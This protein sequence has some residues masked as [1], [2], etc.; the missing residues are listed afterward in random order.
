MTIII[1]SL[2]HCLLLMLLLM[3]GVARHVAASILQWH[4][5]HHHITLA[6]FSLLLSCLVPMT[7]IHSAAFV[8]A[9]PAKE[10]AVRH[11]F[12][13]RALHL[14][15]IARSLAL[16]ETPK[17]VSKGN[18]IDTM[19]ASQSGGGDGEKRK[20]RLKFGKNP[21]DTDEHE[22]FVDT[23]QERNLSLLSGA[24]GREHVGSSKSPSTKKAKLQSGDRRSSGH[25]VQK[26]MMEAAMAMQTQEFM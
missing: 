9:Y 2:Q 12:N 3:G 24:I 19:K 18:Q 15:H 8:R 25:D 6:H 17:M 26:R 4:R 14:G 7:I 13:A 23:E 1:A 21:V 20:S 11:I 22:D 10:K 16:K 5:P